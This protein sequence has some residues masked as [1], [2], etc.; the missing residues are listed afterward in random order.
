[1]SKIVLVTEIARFNQL[2]SAVEE[3]IFQLGEIAGQVEHE[4]G[5]E[6]L[7]KLAQYTGTPLVVVRELIRVARG[8]LHPRLV[9][10]GE[11]QMHAIKQLSFAEQSDIIENGIPVVEYDGED[12]VTKYV[13][14]QDIT[15]RQRGQVFGARKLRSASAQIEYLK[16]R[17]KRERGELEEKQKPDWE[18]IDGVIVVHRPAKIRMR[19]I[20]AALASSEA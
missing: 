15:Q 16:E 13:D 2:K 5:L 9:L 7:K 1:M 20:H 11:T 18:L 10:S 12:Y 8:T 19:E 14:I 17:E 6:G 3:N 4:H